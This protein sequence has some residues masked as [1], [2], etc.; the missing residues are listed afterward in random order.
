[1]GRADNSRA[2]QRPDASEHSFCGQ[3]EFREPSKLNFGTQPVIRPGSKFRWEGRLTFRQ[4][5]KLNFACVRNSGRSQNLILGLSGTPAGD[6]TNAMTGG[7]TADG[8]EPNARA[9]REKG[10]DPKT[11]SWTQPV[12]RRG[13][14]LRWEGCPTLRRVPKYSFGACRNADRGQNEGRGGRKNGGRERTK[15]ADGPGK[16]G[17]RAAAR[18]DTSRTRIRSLTSF[19]PASSLTFAR[20]SIS[21]HFQYA[22]T[23]LAARLSKHAPKADRRYT[24]KFGNAPQAEFGKK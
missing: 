20:M 24:S 10:G 2:N 8:P 13:A 7:K 18:D 9:N 19:G 15:C 12:I 5:A 14:K 16:R 22:L 1:M 17:S 3:P 11:K 6:K 23:S 4:S 21:L